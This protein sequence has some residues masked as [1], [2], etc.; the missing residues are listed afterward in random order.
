MFKSPNVPDTTATLVV[1][2][3]IYREDA[4]AGQGVTQIAVVVDARTQIVLA[5][6]AEGPGPRSWIRVYAER[7]A[8]L[9]DVKPGGLVAIKLRSGEGRPVAEKIVLADADR[10]PQRP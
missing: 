10:V 8:A 1:A 3:T 6:R 4:D 9:E 5:V 2:Q 7:P